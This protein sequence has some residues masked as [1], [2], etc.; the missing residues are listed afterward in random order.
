MIY[1]ILEYVKHYGRILLGKTS[2]LADET[3]EAGISFSPWMLIGLVALLTVC[4]G[5]GFWAASIAGSRKHRM[6]LHTI[7]GFFLPLAYP[8]AILFTLDVH[9][10]KERELAKQRKEEEEKAAEED[11]KRMDK[12]MGRLPEEEEDKPPEPEEEPLDA[13]YF[14]KIS[15]NATGQ[16]TG[17]WLIHYNGQSVCAL[18]IVDCLDQVVVV[19]IETPSGERQR[20][21]IRYALIEGC[22]HA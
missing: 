13:A 11:R 18:H 17:P 14:K 12:V 19:E 20:I 7:L 3:A 6:A 15:R 4:M 22:E 10:A 21:R 1:I 5:S 8:I 2:N 16:L 9:G